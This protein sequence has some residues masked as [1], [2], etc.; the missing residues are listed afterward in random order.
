MSLQD[1]LSTWLM[2]R[3][4]LHCWNVAGS[5]AQTEKDSMLKNLVAVGSLQCAGYPETMLSHPF[6]DPSS[7]KPGT[8]AP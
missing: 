4:R 8:H 1:L 5:L 2:H 6:V 7:T 3:E